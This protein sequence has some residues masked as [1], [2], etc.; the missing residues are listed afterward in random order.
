MIYL[1]SLVEKV[2]L[3]FEYITDAAVNGE[4]LLLDDM[5]IPQ[6]NYKTDFET[7]NGG[8]QSAGFVRMQNRLPQT[9]RVSLVEDGKPRSVQYLQ[10][11]ANQSLHL[12]LNLTSDVTLV[13]SGTTRFTRLPGK[14]TISIT[15]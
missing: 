10:L 12:P 7:D 2:T 13:V 14:Y 8:W 6:I 11:E 9:F 5:E 1:S 15:P 3:Q 4:G